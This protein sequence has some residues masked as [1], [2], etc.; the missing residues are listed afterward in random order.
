VDSGTYYVAANWSAWCCDQELTKITA[1]KYEVDV[2]LTTSVG[3][4][5]LVRNKDWSQIL[6]PQGDKVV[7]PGSASP[8]QSWSIE[9]S[10]GDVYRVVMQRV[11]QG[12]AFATTVSWSKVGTKA[13][14]DVGETSWPRYFLVGTGTTSKFEL[15]PLSNLSYGITLQLTS[16]PVQF[17]ILQ[18]G[19]SRKA[20]YPSETYTTS[21]RRHVILGPEIA[22]DARNCWIIRRDLDDTSEEGGWYTVEM[23]VN[24]MDKTPT[25][26]SW[27]R[28]A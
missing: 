24:P 17:H 4:F 14:S 8:S 6:Y 25:R 26:V 11:W 2:V 27:M 9:G 5:Q 13:I 22:P 15:E 7:G 3:K 10:V 23:R 21:N 18:D 20:F 16:G 28:T 19:D 1:G 12:G